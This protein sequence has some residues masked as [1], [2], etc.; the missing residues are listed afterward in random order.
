MLQPSVHTDQGDENP[1]QPPITY[2]TRLS[3]YGGGR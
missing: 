3:N 1:A 2:V